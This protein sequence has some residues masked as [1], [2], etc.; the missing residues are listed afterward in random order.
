MA[1]MPWNH[2]MVQSLYPSIGD[3]FL[4]RMDHSINVNPPAVANEI[5][6]IARLE[7]ADPNSDSVLSRARE[8]TRDAKAAWIP[9]LSPV[10][11]YVALWL[12]EIAEPEEL[13]KLLKHADTYLTPSWSNGG[14]YY[15]RCDKGWDDN[16]NYTYVDPHTGNAA[17]AYSRLNIKNGQKKM[18]DHP[19]TRDE[20]E[21]RPWI[22]GISFG[23]DIDCL[24][25]E[26]NEENKAMIA[27]F[28]TWNGSRVSCR[29]VIKKLPFGSYGIYVDSHLRSVAHVGNGN[30]EI[31][32][33]LQIG[34]ED[35]DIAVVCAS[36]LHNFQDVL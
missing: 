36:R 26:W 22:D 14:L 32:I 6:R 9:Y 4:H 13:N 30:D 29:P 31:S 35:V 7:N 1:F 23:Q 11:G 20:V 5:R 18:W 17:I 21:S 8:A 12:S 15:K 27:T 34:A 19:W 16:G 28:R 25:G 3:G 33:D 24:R 2:D 10:F